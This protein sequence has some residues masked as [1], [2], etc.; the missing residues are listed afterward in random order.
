MQARRRPRCGHRVYNPAPMILFAEIVGVRC[1]LSLALVVIGVTVP[2]MLF[3]TASKGCEDL[4]TKAWATRQTR[5]G[6][7]IVAGLVSSTIASGSYRE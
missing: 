4:N 7:T 6:H 5:Q 3:L 2:M 1:F